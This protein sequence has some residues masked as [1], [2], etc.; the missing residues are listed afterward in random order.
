M[1]LVSGSGVKVEGKEFVGK[2]NT[3]WE[4]R[5]KSKVILNLQT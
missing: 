1:W 2:L 4:G 5:K 3:E